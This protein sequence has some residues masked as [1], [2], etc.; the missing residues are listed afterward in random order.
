LHLSYFV[1]A[2]QI[3]YNR[4]AVNEKERKMEEK[5]KMALRKGRK[6]IRGF[7]PQWAWADKTAA[8]AMCICS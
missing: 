3:D 8:E 7:Q 2:T 5:E 1:I 6:S 4:R